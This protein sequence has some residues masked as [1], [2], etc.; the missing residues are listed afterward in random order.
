MEMD[1][2]LECCKRIFIS[3]A[4]GVCLGLERKNHLQAIG[5]RTLLLSS[6]ASALMGILSSYAAQSSIIPGDP[7]R[8]SAGVVTGIGFIGGGAI[9][10]Q[11]LNIKGVTTA[12]IIWITSALG[13][14]VGCGLYVP[15]IFTFI[16]TLISLP[17]FEKV[18]DKFFPAGKIKIITL[19]YSSDEIDLSKIKNVL[20][21]AGLVYRDMSIS[22]SFVEEKI[23]VTIYANSPLEIDLIDLG[24]KLQTTG[25]MVKFAFEE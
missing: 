1:F 22:E 24:R 6:I 4:F 16:L 12:A 21:E 17:L 11:G 14:S 5:T 25:N 18:E 20:K 3:F 23:K 8:I 19:I 2:I 9:M 7:T 10:Q 13:L 15:A